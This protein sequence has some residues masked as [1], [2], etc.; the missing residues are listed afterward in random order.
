MLKQKRKTIKPLLLNLNFVEIWILSKEFFIIFQK[1]L[2]M[3]QKKAN[4]IVL[5]FFKILNF[6]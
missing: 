1:I 2:L 6:F 3:N 5:K 4:I